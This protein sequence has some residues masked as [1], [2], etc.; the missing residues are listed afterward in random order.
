MSQ[1]N[2]IGHTVSK[3]TSMNQSNETNNFFILMSE[4]EMT[5]DPTE[6]YLLHGVSLNPVSLYALHK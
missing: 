6:W 5:A 4:I 1:N 2:Y 3:K